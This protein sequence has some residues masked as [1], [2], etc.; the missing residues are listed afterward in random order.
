MQQRLT[1]IWELFDGDLK[2]NNESA[3]EFGGVTYDELH[4]ALLDEFDDYEIEYD[5]IT[6]TKE[7]DQKKFFQ[8]LQEGFPQH[9]T[10]ASTRTLRPLRGVRPM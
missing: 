10:T 8:R 1:A 5:E 6:E 4:D 3:E 7:E 9:L 2:L